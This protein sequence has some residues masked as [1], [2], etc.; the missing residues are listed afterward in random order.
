[1][2]YE[3]MI[4][5]YEKAILNTLRWLEIPVPSGFE[6]CRPRLQ[7]QADAVSEEWVARY[8]A[9]ARGSGWLSCEEPPA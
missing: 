6:I 9:W 7:E 4:V 2:V 1:M 3:D 8:H 5:D